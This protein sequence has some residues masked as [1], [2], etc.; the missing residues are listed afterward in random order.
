MI[1]NSMSSFF[2]NQTEL[3]TPNINK[4]ILLIDGHNLV[5]RLISAVTSAG[6][7]NM[8]TN[9]EIYDS[10]KSSMITNVFS[11]IK[12]FKPNRVIIAFDSSNNW[13][14]SVYSLY[15]ANRKV[16]R[17]K[18][19]LINFKEFWPIME[20]FINTFSL[21]FQNIVILRIDKCEADDIIAAVAVHESVNSD[22]TIITTDSDFNQ[23]LSLKNINIYNPKTHKLVKCLHPQTEL[24]IKI[25]KGDATDNIPA[26][27]KRC[28]PQTAAKIIN[29]GGI[30]EFIKSS[31]QSDV[32]KENYIRNRK[33]IDFNFMPIDIK[34]LILKSY[35]SYNTEKMNTSRLMTFFIN[36]NMG[37]IVDRYNQ[38]S[39]LLNNIR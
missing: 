7:H 5:F 3:N 10:W 35:T 33:L 6:R 11:F 12:K 34:S 18:S 8:L 15:K 26:V 39:Q 27:F 1:K 22:V 14:K 9:S 32:I 19:A 25:L 28:G 16:N 20:E 31:D 23:L 36:N 37:T 2:K 29:N 4:N 13:R 21:I 17:D 24:E 30:H 38:Y